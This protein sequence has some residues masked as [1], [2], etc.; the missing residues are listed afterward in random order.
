MILPPV[1]FP[2]SYFPY[3][4]EEVDVRNDFCVERVYLEFDVTPTGLLKVEIFSA[5]RIFVVVRH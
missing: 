3:H 1:V 4:N 2:G 5:G